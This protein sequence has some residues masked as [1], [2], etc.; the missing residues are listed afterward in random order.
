M[1]LALDDLTANLLRAA[2][3]AGADAADA[4]AMRGMSQS[5]EVRGGVLEHAE[6]AEGIDMGLRVFLGQRTAIVAASDARDATIDE[7]AQRAVAMAREA[8]EDPYAGLASADQIA[9]HIN[10]SALELDDPAP[11]PSPAALQDDATRAEAAALRNKGISQ[12]QS[13]SAGYSKRE[14]FLAATNGFAAGYSRTSRSLSCVAISGSGSAME[15]DYDGDSRVFQNDLRTPE[16][17][18]TSAAERAVARAG[19]RKPPTGSYPVLYDERVAATL[20]G[21]LLVA[22]NGSSVARGASWLL[23]A[24]G[25]RI[26]NIARRDLC[27]KARGGGAADE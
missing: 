8:P 25:E 26:E 9:E 20:I 4:I 19:A 7:M 3:R 14:L 11:E 10:V 15:R 6:R 13:A 5:I 1:T 16:D 12:V 23:D 22:A 27:D 17:I 24:K 21:H 2:K 18:G